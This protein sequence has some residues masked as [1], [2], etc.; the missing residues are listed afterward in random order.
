MK[1]R[2]LQAETLKAELELAKLKG[3]VDLIGNFH[4]AEKSRMAAIR[5]N[6]RNVP[7]RAVL[8]LLGCTDELTF[9]SKLMAEIDLALVTAANS[10]VDFDDDEDED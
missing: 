5:A 1:R 4:R 7:G 9:K 6:M 2:K 3:E 10:E 8:Q